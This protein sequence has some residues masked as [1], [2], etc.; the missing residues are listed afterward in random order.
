MKPSRGFT[1]IEMM[2]AVAI[3]AILMAVAMPSYRT[4]IQNTQIRATAESMQAGLTLARSQALQRNARVSLWLVD[5]VSGACARSSS[6]TSWVVSLDDPTGACAIAAS[7]SATPRLIQSRAGSDGSTGVTVTA[8]D[9]AGPAVASS[10]ITFNGF[11]RVEPACSGGGA[12]IARVT[13]ASATASTATRTL[14]VRV[15]SGGAV[16]TCDPSVASGDPAFC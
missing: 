13:L 8:V 14:Q 15:V 5:G 11:G 1:L 7:D 3:M 16:R 9:G 4:F 10:C 12:P 6:G 2:I